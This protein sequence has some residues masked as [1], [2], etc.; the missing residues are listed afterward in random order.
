MINS[1]ISFIRSTLAY[2]FIIGGVLLWS[3]QNKEKSLYD[4]H[5]ITLHSISLK[6]SDL[7]AAKA[8]YVDLLEFHLESASD[9]QLEMRL[10]D[11]RFLSLTKA[12]TPLQSPAHF[13]IR[14]R[15][16]ISK[17]RDE[18]SSR[19]DTLGKSTTLSPSATISG[20][21]S[22]AKGKEF[23]IQDSDKNTLTF[24]QRSL[25]TRK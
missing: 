22:S 1:N 11:N 10:P 5:L 13:S 7:K 18:L 15:N 6:S 24:F 16:G 25:L 21:Y 23:V 4:R 8:L 12:N 19:I 9:E 14:V 20:V 3:G 17:L 2:V